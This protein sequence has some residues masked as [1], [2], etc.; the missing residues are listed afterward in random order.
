MRGEKTI[1]QSHGGDWRP[2]PNGPR[3]RR[4]SDA[5]ITD[6]AIFT[7]PTPPLQGGES[8]RRS[9]DGRTTCEIP[10]SHP[11]SL[12]LP[13]YVVDRTSFRP[14]SASDRYLPA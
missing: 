6:H 4:L 1:G 5:I 14:H 3:I 11:S 10:A 8:I 2:A 12:V 9:R 13:C 7:P